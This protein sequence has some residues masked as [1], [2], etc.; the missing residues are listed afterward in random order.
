MKKVA[1]IGNICGGKTLLSRRLSQLHNLPL[2]HVDA[3][4]FLPGLKRRPLP[5]SLAQIK[6]IEQQDS[7]LIDGYGPLDL[8][9]S[10]LGQADRIV[11]IDLPLSL[12]IWWTLK[13]QIK[14]LW[15]PRAE[16]PPGC[17]EL[18]LEHTQRLLKS[19]LN[20]HRNMRPELVRILSR[21]DLKHK[22]IYIRSRRQWQKYFQHGLA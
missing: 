18:N 13:R 2:A 9:E 19:L 1:V 17:Q 5:E 6:M 14:N 11:F 8:L 22:V 12:H 3:I 4:E 7:W 15:S 10:R 21:D 20:M 16:L